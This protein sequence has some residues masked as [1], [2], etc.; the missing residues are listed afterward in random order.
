MVVSVCAL[1]RL[2][3]L[4]YG[5]EILSVCYVFVCVSIHHNKGIVGQNDCKIGDVGGTWTLRHFHFTWKKDVKAT[6]KRPTAG[7]LNFF[8]CNASYS[9]MATWTKWSCCYYQLGL[10]QVALH[11]TFKRPLNSNSLK[12]P[13][14]LVSPN[15]MCTILTL[16][17]GLHGL[18]IFPTV[19]I[20]GPQTPLGWSYS[21][22]VAPK[23]INTV[24]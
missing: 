18:C 14:L 20:L 10:C 16:L 22:W 1:S 9:K 7:Y 15:E 17:L 2:N 5:Q 8:A 4:T 21:K 24:R 12:L 11:Y 6:N 3:R 23:D 19:A 13:A